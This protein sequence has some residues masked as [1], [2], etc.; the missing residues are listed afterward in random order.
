MRRRFRGRRGG[1]RRGRRGSRRFGKRRGGRSRL[2]RIGYR[3]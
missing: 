2:L 3:M 1:F